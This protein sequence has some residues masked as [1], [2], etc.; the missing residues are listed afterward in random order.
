MMRGIPE[1]FLFAGADWFGVME[2]QKAKMTE[3]VRG[4]SESQVMN[5]STDD[6]CSYL[7][8]K[9]SID[10]PVLDEGGIQMDSRE[11]QIDVSR[12]P[13]RFFIDR[14]TPFHITGTSIELTIPFSGDG[15][16]FQVRPTTASLNPPRAIVRNQNLIMTFTGTDLNADQLKDRIQAALNEIKTHLDRLRTDSASLHNQLPQ[17]ARTHV[18]ERRRKFLSD[19][20]LVAALG[21]PMKPRAGAPQTYHAPE[22]RRKIQ[23]KP[24]AVSTVAFKPEP[25]LAEADY[26][27]ILS[28]MTNMV[29]V[30]ERSPSAFEKM[31][32]EDLR[33]HF[34]VQLN[35]HYEG[36]AT[37][38]T[39]NYE[40][41]TDILIR[42]AGRNIFI[43]ECKYWSGPK[44]LAETIDQLLGYLSWRDS[45]A[46]IV[47][48][49]RQK[50]F[51]HVLSEIPPAVM[52]HPNFKRDLGK[53][54]ETSFRYKLTH[55]DDPNREMTVTV[56]A[57]DVPQPQT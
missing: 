18:D 36:Q 2:N 47:L 28:V 11:V 7:V 19:Q 40:G 5:A 21:F 12:D 24:P 13:N 50:G 30:M 46:A 27:H 26:E 23:L 1:D 6:L 10:V 53:Q 55:R 42:S 29:L 20:N 3:E 35:G 38:E 34:L 41:K 54:S 51:G 56:M 15:G 52:A 17:L 44:M 49:N 37:G 8:T 43:A 4:F 25:M 57:F 45:K 14:S 9:Y 48:F 22:V 16:A 32:E 33:Q 31:K 39:F